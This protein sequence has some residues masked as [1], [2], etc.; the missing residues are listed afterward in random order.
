MSAEELWE[1]DDLDAAKSLCEKLFRANWKDNI[2]A[3][4]SILAISE[5]M[6]LEQFENHFVKNGYMNDKVI[7]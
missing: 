1:E 7:Q 5:G 6:S 2:G 3:R 4:Y